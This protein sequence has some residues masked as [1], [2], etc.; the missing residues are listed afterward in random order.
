MTILLLLNRRV[1]PQPRLT[2]QLGRAEGT[3]TG[4]AVASVVHAPVLFSFGSTS[5]AT[6]ADALQTDTALSPP[7]VLTGATAPL[8]GMAVSQLVVKIYLNKYTPYFTFDQSKQIIHI[9]CIIVGS[10]PACIILSLYNPLSLVK[11]V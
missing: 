3:A 8:P 9:V 2:G 5:P 7:G 6:P 1:N 4:T 10:D 11:R